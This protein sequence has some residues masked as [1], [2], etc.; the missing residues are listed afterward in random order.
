MT[1]PETTKQA[2]EQGKVFGKGY[3]FILFILATLFFVPVS[4]YAV[5]DVIISPPQEWIDDIFEAIGVD[6]DDFPVTSAGNPLPSYDF[7]SDFV[8]IDGN[9]S[10]VAGCTQSRTGTVSFF[11]D[12]DDG[13]VDTDCTAN[14]IKFGIFRES[15]SFIRFRSEDGIKPEDFV[16]HVLQFNQLLQDNQGSFDITIDFRPDTPLPPPSLSFYGIFLT[17]A[18]PSLSN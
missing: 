9:I 2:D 15:G 18:T 12:F 17:D 1:L 3:I 7:A 14:F 8:S 5:N 11:D 6:L 10:S 4:T 13:Q 16:A